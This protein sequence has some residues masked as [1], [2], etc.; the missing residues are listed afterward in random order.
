M[1]NKTKGRALGH[2]NED[3]ESRGGGCSREEEVPETGG[4]SGAW[5][6]LEVKWESVL[7]WKSVLKWH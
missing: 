2:F 1:K 7:K 5:G 4:N 6:V 3:T